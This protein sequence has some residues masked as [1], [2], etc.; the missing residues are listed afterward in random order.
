MLLLGCD[1]G[2]ATSLPSPFASLVADFLWKEGV[3]NLTYPPNLPPPRHFREGLPRSAKGGP[4]HSSLC[5]GAG[6]SPPPR[7]CPLMDNPS[8]IRLLAICRAA[9]PPAE[10][11]SVTSVHA[12]RLLY[13]TA[14]QSNVPAAKPVQRK[15]SPTPSTPGAFGCSTFLNRACLRRGVR[16]GKERAWGRDWRGESENYRGVVNFSS[17]LSIF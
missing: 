15:E 8:P 12:V 9:P 16:F 5:L 4:L 3:K 13:L 2:L 7:K 1:L 10:G 6:R 11:R 17:S 14:S